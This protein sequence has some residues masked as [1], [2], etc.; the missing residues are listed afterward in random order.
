MDRT[1]RS[2]A[3][4]ASVLSTS[5]I[6]YPHGCADSVSPGLLA[7]ARDLVATPMSEAGT[8]G[9]LADLSEEKGFPIRA[10]GMLFP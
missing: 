9:I 10:P 3:R 7:G 2:L 4:R 8:K 1:C 6:A 5:C